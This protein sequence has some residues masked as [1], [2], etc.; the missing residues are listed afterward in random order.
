VKCCYCDRLLICDSCHQEFRPA[1]A[2]E[3]RNLY[4]PES[5]VFCPACETVLC[6]RDCGAIYSGSD[7]EYLPEHHRE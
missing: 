5:P 7:E 2:D 1:S 3:F 6:C 4:Q